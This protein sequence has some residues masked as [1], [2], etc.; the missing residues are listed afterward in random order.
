MRF[1]NWCAVITVLLFFTGCPQ[2][3]TPERDPL[4]EEPPPFSWSD[5]LFASEKIEDGLTLTNFK[6]NDLKYWTHEGATVWTVWG[7]TGT[8]FNSRKVSMSKPIG[9]SGGGYGIVFCH[10]IHDIDG[11]SVPVMLVVMINNSEQYIIGKAVG[12]VFTDFGWWKSTPHLRHGAGSLNEI[13]VIYEE[14]IEKYC[15]II[16]GNI[17]E[18]FSDD[19]DDYPVLRSGRNGYIAVI[20]PFDNFPVSG[21]DIYFWEKK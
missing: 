16:N 10:N 11:E 7:E 2:W 8:V 17:I 1:V 9:F 21:I 14:D 15:L 20:T 19:N 13:I 6:T 12:G 4:P 5:E 3:H 18:R